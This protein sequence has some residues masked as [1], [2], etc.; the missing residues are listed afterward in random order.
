MR[1]HIQI[2]YCWIF[3][4]KK[5]VLKL[6]D[7][8]I[9]CFALSFAAWKKKPVTASLKLELAAWCSAYDRCVTSFPAFTLV[10]PTGSS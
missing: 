9:V 2:L 3:K 1:Q 6:K 8:Q 10:S 4:E 7:E 5:D